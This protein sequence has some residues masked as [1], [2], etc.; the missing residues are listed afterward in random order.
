MEAMK[1]ARHVSFSLRRRCEGKMENTGA[2][3]QACRQH[4]EM[5]D[6]GER[7]LTRPFGID[8]VTPCIIRGR[9]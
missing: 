4:F 5:E 1:R 8:A 3:V 2:G 6:G 7:S 9:M